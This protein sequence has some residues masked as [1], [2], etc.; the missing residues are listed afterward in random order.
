M[1]KSIIERE[2]RKRKKVLNRSKD[3]LWKEEEV[4]SSKSIG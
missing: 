2:R 4:A 1:E 3:V